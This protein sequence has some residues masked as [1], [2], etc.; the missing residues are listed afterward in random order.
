MQSFF[1]HHMTL[2]SYIKGFL[3]LA[4]TFRREALNAKPLEQFE[5]RPLAPLHEVT[6][7]EGFDAVRYRFIRQGLLGHGD[8]SAKSAGKGKGGLLSRHDNRS[9]MGDTHLIYNARVC[10]STGYKGYWSGTELG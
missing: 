7:D 2:Q 5:R 3:P 10:W 9:P 6:A 4:L 1:S 8:A